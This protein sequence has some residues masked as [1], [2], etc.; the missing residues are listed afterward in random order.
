MAQF[1]P[2]PPQF[3]IQAQV[4]T[5]DIGAGY[6]AGITEAGK[7]LAAATSG[8]MDVMRRNQNATDMLNAMQQ[9][10][11]LTPDQYNAVAGKSLG[12]KEQMLGMYASQWALQQAQNRELQKQGYAG[13][14]EQ[15]VSH[16]KL[17][18]TLAA[19]RVG[20]QQPQQQP[21][22][23]PVL[24][25][26]PVLQPTALTG[27]TQAPTP[28]AAGPDITRPLAAQGPINPQTGRPTGIAGTPAQM[29]RIGVPLGKG[30]AIPPG[31]TVRQIKGPKGD[32]IQGVLQPDGTFR[33][34]S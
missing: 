10:K 18:D 6:A 13:N 12:A 29:T 28:L 11:M 14:I 3:N 7:S 21:V 17:L 5:R 32:I 34:R 8:V 27:T 23:Q 2:T 20:Q 26:R 30:E 1:D 22:Q 15:Q 31:A 25:G 24:P 33:P 4:P 16:A 9:T 19:N